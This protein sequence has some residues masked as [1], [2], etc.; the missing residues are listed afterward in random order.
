ML[1]Q[2]THLNWGSVTNGADASGSISDLDASVT[3]HLDSHWSTKD[4]LLKYKHLSIIPACMATQVFQPTHVGIVVWLEELSEE[5]GQKRLSDWSQSADNSHCG[6]GFDAALAL[7]TE[8]TRHQRVSLEFNQKVESC[9]PC[10]PLSRW[11]GRWGWLLTS[12]PILKRFH[13][14]LKNQITA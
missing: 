8:A 13:R 3:A 11:Q 9:L 14:R 2:I 4:D 5:T 7:D 1:L 6:D 10:A 12:R